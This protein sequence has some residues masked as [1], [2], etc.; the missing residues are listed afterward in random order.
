MA[1]VTVRNLTNAGDPLI[2]PDGTVLANTRVSFDLVNARGKMVSLFDVESGELVSANTVRVVTD[3]NGEFSVPLWPNNR[4]EVPSAYRVTV[5]NRGVTPFLIRVED[6]TGDLLLVDARRAMEEMSPQEIS[7][8]AG[9]MSDIEGKVDLAQAWATKTDGEVVEGEGYGAK[10]YA[11]DAAASAGQ[12]ADALETLGEAVSAAQAW[13]T[14]TDGEV[15]EGEGYG[16]KKYAQDAAASAEQVAAALETL[17]EMIEE[18]IPVSELATD[19]EHRFVTDEQIEG[20]DSKADALQDHVDKMAA[21]D[22]AGHIRLATVLEALAGANTTKAVTPQGLKAA[23]DALIAA[24]P[25]ALDTLDELAAALNDD[26]NFAA[27][28]TAL[29]AAKAPLESP[30]LTGEPTAPT[31]APGSSTEQLATCEFVQVEILGRRSL[32]ING[33]CHVEQRSIPT[34]SASY[35]YGPVDRFA[36]KVTPAPSG[37]TLTSGTIPGYH[38]AVMLANVTVGAGGAVYFRYR[39]EA[40]DC[41]Q[42]YNQPA[43]FSCRIYH[44]A[45]APINFTIAVR[46]ATVV[47]NFASVTN[48]ATSAA[49]VV[50]NATDTTIVLENVAMGDC[51][52]GIEIEISGACGAVTG[53][54]FYCGAIYV[55]PGPVAHSFIPNL[56]SIDLAACQRY[57]E[58]GGCG[59]SAVASGSSTAAYI[60]W[61]FKGLKRAVPAIGHTGNPITLVGDSGS[62]NPSSN[63][64]TSANPSITGTRVLSLNYS[65]LTIGYG[66]VVDRDC[67]YADA[68]L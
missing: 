26:A 60:G 64:L 67:L 16:A 66:Y 18:G 14:K 48:I 44:N 58:V 55:C 24:A 57:F 6:G 13:A 15:V 35:Q 39:M 23:L 27:T 61:Q 38:R 28:I 50:A 30:P 5:S 8:F 47:D 62:F 54:D 68:E 25:A 4:G 29:L 45:G 32:I 9:A 65:G 19:P 53:K 7:W 37:G 56:L 22:T 31:A 17:G 1:D 11:D 21:E 34:L 49:Q 12:V 63:S 3:E 46:K 10:K 43:S 42:L 59:A 33:A 52:N 36:A 41:W 20:W 40:R 2:M 51:S